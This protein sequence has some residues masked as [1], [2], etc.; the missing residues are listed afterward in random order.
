MEFPDNPLVHTLDGLLSQDGMTVN[1]INEFLR[2]A[3]AVIT[4]GVL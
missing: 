1:T 2:L 3:K 4:L